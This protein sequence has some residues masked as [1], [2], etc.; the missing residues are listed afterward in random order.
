MCI[1]AHVS[2]N[3]VISVLIITIAV[4][5]I[6]YF[7]MLILSTFIFLITPLLSLADYAGC[8]MPNANISVGQHC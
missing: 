5:Q 3:V 1:I 4:H 8:L 6:N 7:H 2:N